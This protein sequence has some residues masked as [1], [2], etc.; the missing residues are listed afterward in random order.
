MT[1]LSYKVSYNRKMKNNRDKLWSRLG[2]VMI[3]LVCLFGLLLADMWPRYGLLVA[4]IWQTVVDGL[5]SIVPCNMWA[6]WMFLVQF[7]NL[8]FSKNCLSIVCL[9]MF[10]KSVYWNW[11]IIDTEF[12]VV[13]VGVTISFLVMCTSPKL[14]RH[15][16]WRLTLFIA[17]NV[18]NMCHAVLCHTT[19]V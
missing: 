9:N 8:Y 4:Q 7:Y 13:P 17:S 2:S 10:Y 14:W 6:G 19:C 11:I 18:T 15:Y 1:F 3:H 12:Y 5:G 16:K